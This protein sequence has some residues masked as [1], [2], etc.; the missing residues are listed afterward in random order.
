[1]KKIALIL[2]CCL[3]LGMSCRPLPK[4]LLHKT[5]DLQVKPLQQGVYQHISWIELSNG[6]SFP[7]NGM[8]YEVGEE[9]VVFDSPVTD[10]AT[11]DLIRWIEER[12]KKI[13]G[14]VVNHFH[15]DCTKGLDQFVSRNVPVYMNLRTEAMLNQA[16]PK[17]GY[18]LFDLEQ[19]LQL[20]PR[21]VINRY[22]GPAHTT[23]NIVSYLPAEKVLFGGCQV[24]S[25]G[26][27]KGNLSDADTLVWPKNVQA[28]Q[29]AYP[30]VQLIIPGHGD[31]GGIPLLEYTQKLFSRH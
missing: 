2:V 15:E 26:A 9:V 30:R 24:K 23:D 10:Q 1:M 5:E 29:A 7:C 25:Y 21:K 22:F 8:I 27:S 13:K 18:Q 11:E 3:S 17:Q 12:G 4:P 19:T 28:I 16:A 31:P 20:G 14:L 6:T